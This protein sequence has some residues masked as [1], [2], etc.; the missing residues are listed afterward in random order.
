MDLCVMCGRELPTECSSQVCKTCELT[1]GCN[2]MILRCPECGREMEIWYKD[3]TRY[4]PMF[5]DS[6]TRMTVDL[7][8]HCECG[9]DWDSR[10][11]TLYGSEMQTLPTRHYWG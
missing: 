7:I 5:F 8:Y 2:F 11:D 1:T 9:C 6:F 4:E 3:I 10:Y